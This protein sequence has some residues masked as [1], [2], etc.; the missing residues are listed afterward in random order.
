MGDEMGWQTAIC[1]ELSRAHLDVDDPLNVTRGMVVEMRE[2]RVAIGRAF[3]II[4]H[5][6]RQ[7]GIPI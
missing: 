4:K 2:Q 6:L 5:D 1:D 7:R 3:A